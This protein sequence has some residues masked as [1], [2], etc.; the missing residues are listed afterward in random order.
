MEWGVGGVVVQSFQQAVA[1]AFGLIFLFLMIY[2]RGWKLP[3]LVFIPIGVTVVLTFA[4]CAVMNISLNMA[5]IL[6]VPLILGL[7]VDTGIHIVHRHNQRQGAEGALIR[8]SQGWRI[9]GLTTGTFFPQ[10][11]SPPGGI[12]WYPTFYRYQHTV[13]HQFSVDAHI[14]S[15]VCGR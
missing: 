8:H 5:N 2:F 9:S 1:A 10:F 3:L 7:G 12:H 13:D 14:A 15:M 4:I 11:E 6:M